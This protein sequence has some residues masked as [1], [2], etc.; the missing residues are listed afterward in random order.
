MTPS[1]HRHFLRAATGFSRLKTAFTKIGRPALP[2]RSRLS[3]PAFLSRV[4]VGQQLSTSAARS[5]WARVEIAVKANNGTIPD[6]FTEQHRRLLRQCGISNAKVQALIA[7]REAHDAG[8]L[9]VRRLRCMNH[10]QRS[11][12]L[13][14][15]WGIGQW[16]ADMTSIF[17]FGDADVWPEGDMGV[18]R[19][20]CQLTGKRSKSALA[21][22][23]KNFAP[24]RSFLAL[25]MWRYLDNP[26]K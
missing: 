25:Y 4:I 19:A 5:I 10:A 18:Y 3:L 20:L 6:F 13:T 7:V 15:I 23:A 22:I 2:A 8:L 21:K 17:Y 11:E 26:P 16:T 24:Y 9:S 1:V 14:E 12:F